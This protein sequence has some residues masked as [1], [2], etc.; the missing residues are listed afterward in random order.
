MR[1]AENTGRKSNA[2]IA[3][4]A[5]PHNV[6]F[7]AKACIDNKK[8]QQYLIH[9]PSQYGELRPTNGWDQLAS[10]GHPSK[11]QRFPVLASLLHRR[12]SKEVNQTLRGVWPSFALVHYA[13]WP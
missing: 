2:K 7:A 11:F 3:I 1:L 5:L 4:W 6:V 12:R 9:I 10:L 8:K 13:P